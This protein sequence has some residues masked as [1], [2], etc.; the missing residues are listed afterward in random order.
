MKIVYQ[1]LIVQYIYLIL[2]LKSCQKLKP[3]KKIK[4][5]FTYA[6]MSSENI[7]SNILFCYNNTK[8]FSEC[9]EM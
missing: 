7:L 3:N 1:A 5:Y 6:I 4:R 2:I 9:C 8:H